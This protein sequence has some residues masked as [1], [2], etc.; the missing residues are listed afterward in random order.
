MG[1][2]PQIKWASLPEANS[3]AK[4]VET[5]AYLFFWKK[6]VKGTYWAAEQY[7]VILCSPDIY[8]ALPMLF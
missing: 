8:K 1:N 5:G 2:F 7:C 6:S 3:V 4:F